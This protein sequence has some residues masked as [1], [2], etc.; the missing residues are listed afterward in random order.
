MGVSVG[1]WVVVSK[2]CHKYCNGYSLDAHVSAILY[3]WL[4]FQHHLVWYDTMYRTNPDL[5]PANNED[6]VPPDDFC[7]F[8]HEDRY[9]QLEKL[10]FITEDCIQALHALV[11]LPQYLGSSETPL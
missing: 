2:Q 6:K 3:H 4:Y 8:G 5:N 11:R 7:M 10:C 9:V 1:G